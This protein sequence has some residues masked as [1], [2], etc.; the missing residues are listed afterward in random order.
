MTRRSILTITF[1]GAVAMAPGEFTTAQSSPR[2]AIIAIDP[3]AGNLT[4]AWSVNESGAVAGT[5]EISFGNSNDQAYLW[6][7]GVIEALGA[8]PGGCCSLGFGVNDLGH[9]VGWS[10]TSVFGENHAFLSR[11]GEMINLGTL[12]GP[13]STA[14][15]IN[16]HDQIVGGSEYTYDDSADHAFLW[17]DGVILDLGAFNDTRYSVAYDINDAGEVVGWSDTS[18][19]WPYLRH[20]FLWRDG[21]LIDLGTMGGTDSRA[22]SIN[23][24]GVVVGRAGGPNFNHHAAVW[25]DGI[26]LDL[27]EA[28]DPDI[29]ASRCVAINNL[30][31][32]IGHFWDQNSGY[33]YPVIWDS[34][35]APSRRLEDD[36]PP[37]HGWDLLFMQDLNDAG[38]IV[39][40][41]YDRQGRLRGVLLTPVE[42]ALDLSPVT[43]GLAEQVNGVRASGAAPGERIHFVYSTLG[44]G[45]LIPGC[46]A[47]DAALQL[48]TPALIGSARADAD[49]EATL[50]FFVPAW[51]R[52]RYEY[53]IQAVA[54]DS[55][56]VSGITSVRFQ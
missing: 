50:R 10:R 4:Q 6:R 1:A 52:G 7:E 32:I 33:G 56:R 27:H 54:R 2:Y 55:C 47:Q 18:S 41:A 5:T 13:E 53:F 28:K 43:P 29:N 26:I 35:T 22:A 45:T 42:H 46:D 8:L 37:N 40:D 48:D 12:G 31:E 39:G 51:A 21:A 36:L 15:A 3:V 20:A 19:T 23:E 17:D 34:D 14:Y 49:G 24:L 44:G 9:V 11:D 25:R 16:N 30:G 38:Q